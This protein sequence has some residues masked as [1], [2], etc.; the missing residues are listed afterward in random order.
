M[1]VKRINA[2][3]LKRG[4]ATHAGDLLAYMNSPE[5]PSELRAALLDYFRREKMPDFTGERLM[6]LG[7]RNFIATTFA[8]QR[9]EMMALAQEAVR[10]PNPIDHW[11]LSWREGEFP[12][13]AQVDRTVEMFAAHMSL[14]S[15]QCIYAVHGDTHNRHVHIALNR[16]DQASDRMKTAGGGFSI[17]EAHKA[18]AKIEAQFGWTPEAGALYSTRDGEVVPTATADEKRLRD[19]PSLR[20]EANAYENRTGLRSL[21]RVAQEDVLPLIRISASWF[22]LHNR[23]A[24]HGFEYVRSKSTNG[25]AILID[26][27]GVKCSDVSRSVTIARL[28]RRFGGP[29]EPRLSKGLLRTRDKARD[30]LPRAFRGEEFRQARE[31]ATAPPSVY[32]EERRQEI[33]EAIM[34]IRENPQRDATDK[35]ML[36]ILPIVKEQL[37]SRGVRSRVAPDLEHWL[38]EQDEDWAAERWRKRRQ[39]VEEQHLRGDTSSIATPDRVGAYI[40][41]DCAEG[42]RYAKNGQGTAFIDHGDYI[43]VVPHR[44][45]DAVAAALALAARKFKG[46]LFVSGSVE[47]KLSV[48]EQATRLGISDRIAGDDYTK[49]LADYQRHTQATDAKIASTPVDAQDRASETETSQVFDKQ[50]QISTKPGRRE[51]PKDFGGVTGLASKSAPQEATSR[52]T[53]RR[54]DLASASVTIPRHPA[55]KAPEVL[56]ALEIADLL[57]LSGKHAGGDLTLM[58]DVKELQ[59][60]ST[61]V[62]RYLK[63]DQASLILHNNRLS[64]GCR[65]DGVK[66]DINALIST[67]G[68]RELLIGIAQRFLGGGLKVEHHV[69]FD[70]AQSNDDLAVSRDRGIERQ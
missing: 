47:F 30:V 1:I 68:G 37:G 58:V 61:F 7:A 2:W 14:D 40:G 6:H 41:Y 46:P 15:H 35:S 22:D 24:K 21:Q 42:R 49:W 43:M 63:S 39:E 31:A 4:R 54:N 50:K 67:P 18:V 55:M 16:Y 9:A 52:A 25:A 59:S 64:A 27:E 11:L 70:I 53:S 33:D 26:G 62:L 65:S 32:A 36:E 23:L 60:L 29:F 28:E 45:S 20:P 19:Q 12:T 34:R 66:A 8:G 48:Y 56:S 5:K 10:S 3:A 69:Y 57:R 13:A 44:G 17:T 51:Q 38:R